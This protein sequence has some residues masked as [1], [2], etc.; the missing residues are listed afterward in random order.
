MFVALFV[1]GLLLGGLVIGTILY[2]TVGFTIPSYVW[3]PV[4]SF[5][6]GGAVVGIIW[7]YF[8]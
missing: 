6:G 4:L 3:I 1:L 5:V 8:K 2:F 7:S